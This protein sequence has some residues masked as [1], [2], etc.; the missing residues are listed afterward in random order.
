MKADSAQG[1]LTLKKGAA[2]AG[3][4]KTYAYVFAV[5]TAQCKLTT[6]GT[7]KFYRATDGTTDSAYLPDGDN[8]KTNQFLDKNDIGDI[9]I[10]MD[11]E[12]KRPKYANVMV[13][14]PKPRSDGCFKFKDG[15]YEFYGK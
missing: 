13:R 7:A 8:V 10:T 4:E 3:S 5:T 1:T 11:V 15:S 9:I 6:S 2:G 14:D 12:S